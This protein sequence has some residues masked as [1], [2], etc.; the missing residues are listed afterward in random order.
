MPVFSDATLYAG[1]LM[2]ISKGGYVKHYFAE[3]ERILSN[4]SGGGNSLVPMEEEMFYHPGTV[5]F[6]KHFRYQKPEEFSKDFTN[7]VQYYFNEFMNKYGCQYNGIEL[8]ADLGNLPDLRKEFINALNQGI[9]DKLY[10][11]HGNHLGSGSMITDKN[12]QTYQTLAYAPY[13]E[14]LVNIKHYQDNYDEKYRFTGQI[15]DE[16]SGLYLFG[17]RHFS[18]R[19]NVTPTT[20]QHWYNY[21]HIT[22][23]NQQGWCPT[24]ITDPTGMDWVE[25]DGGKITWD[26]NVTSQ[27]TAGKGQT[28]LGKNV[29]VGTHNRDANLNE[30]INS[31]RFDLYLE[32]N[33]EGPTAT[34]FGNTVPADVNKHGT[35][36]EG[37]YPA[38]EQGRE[39]Y[40]R[41]GK[42]DLALIINE[43]KRVPC[44]PGSA[45][46]TMTEIFFHAGNNNRE[47]LSDNNGSPYS[48]GCQTGGS[49]S[50]SYKAYREFALKFSNFKGS[51]YLRSNVSVQSK[52]IVP[53]ID[54]LFGVPNFKK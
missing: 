24:M 20:D 44:A 41:Q 16:E 17:I 38:R 11:F 21:P 5:K 13:G 39:K 1:N 53:F 8:K 31:A 28:W 34:I 36:A 2:T 51:Y 12:G 45:K 30:P 7:F 22:S 25:G 49:Y 50:G 18:P 54:G 23:Y 10:Y 46:E 48:A 4:V 29:L 26:D 40:L 35:L 32:S 43:G 14:D 52:S 42:E 27:K 6:P 37:L 19:D 9:S 3:N 15:Y 47:A 33:K